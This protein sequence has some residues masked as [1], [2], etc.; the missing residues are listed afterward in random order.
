ME[1]KHILAR[2]PGPEA[3]EQLQIYRKTLREKSK[4]LKVSS[5]CPFPAKPP[6][7]HLGKAAALLEEPGS[8]M[9][10]S[11]RVSLLSPPLPGAAQQVRATSL[12][13]D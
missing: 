1:L 2:Q 8:P 11:P 7:A 12:L 3:A 6:G 13:L 4:Q 10:R 9:P 5:R